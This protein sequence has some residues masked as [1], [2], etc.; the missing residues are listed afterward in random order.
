MNTNK[1]EK[2][3]LIINYWHEKSLKSLEAAKRE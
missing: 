3:Q 2:R 1:E